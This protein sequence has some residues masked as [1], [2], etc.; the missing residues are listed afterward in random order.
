[1]IE[2]SNYRIAIERAIINTQVQGRCGQFNESEVRMLLKAYPERGLKASRD[3]REIG[4]PENIFLIHLERRAKAIG[5]TV[6]AAPVEITDQMRRDAAARTAA[7]IAEDE[8]AAARER[9]RL[10]WYSKL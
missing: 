10:S 8:A 3:L 6:T 4:C 9:E 2:Y 1:M 7:L 5:L